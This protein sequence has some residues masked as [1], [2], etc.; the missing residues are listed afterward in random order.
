MVD[1]KEGGGAYDFA[2]EEGVPAPREAP[3]PVEQQALPERVCP[4]CGFRIVGKAL[5]GR[6]PECSAALDEPNDRLQFSDPHW[7]ATV[8]NGTLLL[9]LAIAG[10]AAGIVL[11]W[12][13][14]LP[15]GALVHALAATTGA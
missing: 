6:C 4:H 11:G 2:P 7:L 14:K 15:L 10:Q 12:M 9:A 1:K 5:R 8:S 3:A 13:D